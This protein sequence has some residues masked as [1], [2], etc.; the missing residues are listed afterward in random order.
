MGKKTLLIVD[1]E[2]NIR[3]IL[4]VAFEK[5]GYQVFTAESG[6]EALSMLETR[7]ADCVLTDVT[8]PGMTGYELLQRIKAK[9]EETPVV[10]MTAYGTIPQAVQAMRDGAHEYVTKPFDLDS[11]KKVVAGAII[12]GPA[13]TSSRSTAKH[14]P[15]K[16]IAE[17]PQMKQILATI[18]RVADSRATVLIGGE[19]GVGKEV[20][21]RA[22]HEYS[23]RASKPYVAV[24]CAALPETLLESELFGY[25]KGAFTGAQGA[26]AGRFELANE[27]TLFLDEIGEVPLPIQV[28]LL[29]VLQEREFERLGSTRSTRVNVRLITA[30]NRD[31]HE[32]VRQG[33]FRLDLLYRLQVV[34][35]YIPPLRERA[36]DIPALA[37]HFIEKF[38]K[39]NGRPPLVLNQAALASLQKYSWPGNVR[40]LENTI[41]RATVLSSPSD[42]ELDIAL[43]PA[44]MTSAA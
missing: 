17:S 22:L 16:I 14:A 43:L 34:E 39:E 20:V 30:S 2:E 9:N 44:A 26:R 19:S 7:R 6:S 1:D 18:E 4:Q 29:R 12:E 5:S 25:E 40:E 8:M 36:D 41:E 21:A 42:T 10:I 31:L 33:V 32:A 27:G 3:R 28:K 23:A 37:S 35:L 15:S 11:L 13:T 38:A 24:S